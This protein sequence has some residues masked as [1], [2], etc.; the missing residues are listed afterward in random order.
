MKKIK[1]VFLNVGFLIASSEA[2]A[3]SNASMLSEENIII[4]ADSDDM[5]NQTLTVV[6]GKSVRVEHEGVTNTIQFLEFDEHSATLKLSISASLDESGKIIR[7]TER[8]LNFTIDV[9]LEPRDNG[10]YIV[11]Y[12]GGDVDAMNKSAKPTRLGLSKVIL[13]EASV[14]Q[15]INSFAFKINNGHFTVKRMYGQRK[16]KLMQQLF[17]TKGT[18]LE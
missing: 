10:P 9:N 5:M 18:K 4:L 11:T 15:L 6:K 1:V 13:T 14:Q 17:M 3:L 7:N 8:L 16:G 2:F 12:T